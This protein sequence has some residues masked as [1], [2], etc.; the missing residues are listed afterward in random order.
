[1]KII[2]CQNH[3]GCLLG[4]FTAF[5]PHSDPNIGF[6]QRFQHVIRVLQANLIADGLSGLAM[7]S[8]DHFDLDARLQALFYR[9]DGTVFRRINDT[10]DP[11]K[12]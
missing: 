2:V 7:V 5:D 12:G 8:C 3:I 9:F 1:M 4:Y 11:D 10:S 6:F